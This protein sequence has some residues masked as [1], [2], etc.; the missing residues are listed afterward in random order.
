MKQTLYYIKK[1]KHLFGAGRGWYSTIKTPF[2]L[3]KK[4]VK[5]TINEIKEHFQILSFSCWSIQQIRSYFHHLPNKFITFVYTDVDSIGPVYDFLR[6]IYPNT[7]LN[8]G[9]NEVRKNFVIQENTMILRPEISEEPREG[10]FARIEKILVDLYIEKDRLNLI[11]GWE[12]NQI[13]ENITQQF[14]IDISKL[15]RYAYRRKVR[16]SIFENIY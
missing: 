3:E 12:Y 5:G 1:E 6:D 13:F 11:D 10:H 15:S 4:P 7:Y 9:Q 8:P 14:R 16:N 2:R